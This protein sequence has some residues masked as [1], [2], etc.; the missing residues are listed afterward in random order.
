MSSPFASS[1]GQGTLV[2]ASA[3]AGTSIGLPPGVPA[4][5]PGWQWQIVHLDPVGIGFEQ[6]R[7]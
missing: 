6:V 7:A 4:A 1:G 5:P 3:A 2:A